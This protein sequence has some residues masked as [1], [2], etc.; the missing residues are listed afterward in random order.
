MVGRRYLSEASMK[1][2]IS[3][4]AKTQTL[5]TQTTE[6]EDLEFPRFGGHVG[7]RER[8]TAETD[9]ERCSTD[10]CGAS[11]GDLTAQLCRHGL[12][13][14]APGPRRRVLVLA[15]LPL[16]AAGQVHALEAS[17]TARVAPRPGPVGV[18]QSAQPR[19]MDREAGMT[20]RWLFS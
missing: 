18:A 8:W 20:R 3:A 13:D 1:L 6:Q 4:G 7:V 5:P 19:H 15:S 2:A 17:G 10:S 11:A 14:C 9:L 12:A 16:A